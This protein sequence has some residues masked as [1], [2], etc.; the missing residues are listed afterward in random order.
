MNTLGI[1]GVCLALLCLGYRFY[2]RRIEKL[3]G[4][5]PE[6]KTP[7]ET[8]YDGVDYVPAK[9]WFVLFG[10]HFAAIAGAAPIIGPVIAISVWG[11]GPSLI[12]IVVGCIFMGAV[13]DFGSL[14]TSIRY[15]GRSIAEIGGEVIG[16][17]TRILF[18]I[19]IW[20]TLILVVA[21]FVFFSAKT[22]VEDPR[23]VMPSMGLIPI[24]ML[25][26]FMLY[27][28]KMNQWIATIIG[29]VLMISFIVAGKFFPVNLG[30]NSLMIWSIVLLVYCFIAS[31]IPVHIL[32]QPRDYLCGLLLV[33]GMVSGYAGLIITHPPVTQPAFIAWNGE[34]GMLWPMLFVTI[35][36]GAISGF[37]SLVASGT[38][39]KQLANERDAKKIGYGAML[40][41]GA[42][43][44]LALVA[45]LAGFKTHGSLSLMMAKGGPGPIAAFSR[46]YKTITQPFFGP[47]GGLVA[48]TILNSFILS[49]LDAGTRIGRYITH[50]LF[51]I[52]NRYLSTFI[53]VALSA[54]LALSGKWKQ[55]WPIFG[56]ANQL[57]AA[58][59]L[60]VITGWLIIQK[61]P[62]RYTL[63][64]A[65]FVLVTTIGALCFNVLSFYRQNDFLLMGTAIVLIILSFLVLFEA[66]DGFRKTRKKSFKHL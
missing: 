9:H 59:A 10:H 42:V 34:T 5:E 50:E 24:A 40:M 62:I 11:W 56:A 66:I 39:S 3:Y 63:L 20:L 18:S 54:I 46:G 19:F 8:N 15:G 41:E 2:G 23:V 44:I 37:H 25:L 38:S 33:A 17:R 26:G 57:V 60:L 64:P 12:W 36:C 7:A 53:M 16:R 14:V 28:L 6:R 27:S 21:V 48:V 52:K 31:V 13:H 45:I 47:Y 22:Y 43:S 32:L 49:S 29:I 1:A 4:I 51:G 61:K 35:A 58:L 55:L 30:S 65:I